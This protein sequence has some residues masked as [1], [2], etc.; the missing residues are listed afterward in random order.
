MTTTETTSTTTIRQAL[1]AIRADLAGTDY[2]SGT[3]YYLCDQGELW[4][5]N[6]KVSAGLLLGVFVAELWRNGRVVRTCK[7]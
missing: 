6:K 5:R 7:V 4:V 2:I 1:K 3:A